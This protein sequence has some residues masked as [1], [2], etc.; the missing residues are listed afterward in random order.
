MCVNFEKTLN[1][2]TLSYSLTKWVFKMTSGEEVFSLSEKMA[3]LSECLQSAM[4]QNVLSLFALHMA[5]PSD[6]TDSLVLRNLT[7]RILYIFKVSFS[8]SLSTTDFKFH[9][10][11]RRYPQILKCFSTLVK[12]PFTL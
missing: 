6:S 5:A 1:V 8:A 11:T 2:K 4:K 9:V 12:P 3:C 7:T 10:I